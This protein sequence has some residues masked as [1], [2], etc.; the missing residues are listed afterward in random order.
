VCDERYS[1]ADVIFSS[2]SKR[3]PQQPREKK[4]PC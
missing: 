4:K 2:V 3:F 1:D